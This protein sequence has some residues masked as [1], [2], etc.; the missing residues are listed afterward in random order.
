[1]HTPHSHNTNTSLSTHTNVATFL[2]QGFHD[3]MLEIVALGCRRRRSVG[4]MEKKTVIN[5]TENLKAHSAPCH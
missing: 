5:D 3:D 1:M 2:R 4:D